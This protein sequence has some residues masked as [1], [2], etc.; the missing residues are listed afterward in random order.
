[1]AFGRMRGR[2]RDRRRKRAREGEDIERVGQGALVSVKGT[3]QRCNQKL[4]GTE[5]AHQ[6]VTCHQSGEE[7]G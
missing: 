1:M 2:E 5:C 6:A 7:T 3:A 4:M